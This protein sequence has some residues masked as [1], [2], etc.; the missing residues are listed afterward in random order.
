M[1]EGPGVTKNTQ[2]P[3]TAGNL[4][5]FQQ[6]HDELLTVNRQINVN[7]PE[8]INVAAKPPGYNKLN[9]QSTRHWRF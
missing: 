3:T 6:P 4:R 5:E 2:K 8:N 1:F 7:V 9:S